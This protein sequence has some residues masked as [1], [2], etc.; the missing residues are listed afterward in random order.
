MVKIKVV[1]TIFEI[2]REAYFSIPSP[3]AACLLQTRNQGAGLSPDRSPGLCLFGHCGLRGE[4]G[5]AAAG[6]P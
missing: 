1:I 4:A 5:L 2:K 3:F 6:S